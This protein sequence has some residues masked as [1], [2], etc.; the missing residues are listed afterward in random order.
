MLPIH[1]TILCVMCACTQVAIVR[2]FHFLNWLRQ[3]EDPFMPYL[4]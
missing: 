2:I 1:Y 4:V 3:R